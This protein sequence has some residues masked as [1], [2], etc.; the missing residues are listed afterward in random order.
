MFSGLATVILFEISASKFSGNQD[1]LSAAAKAW[2]WVGVIVVAIVLLIIFWGFSHYETVFQET[3]HGLS[4]FKFSY[5]EFEKQH[6]SL[7]VLK[8]I[9]RAN[10]SIYLALF[11]FSLSLVLLL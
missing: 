3:S 7:N 8:R 4:K 10:L 1:T 5:Q 9:C 2:F 11:M 6:N